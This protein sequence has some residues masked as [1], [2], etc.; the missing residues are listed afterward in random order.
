MQ[1]AIHADEMLKLM[2]GM[3]DLIIRARLCALTDVQIDEKTPGDC[4]TA[5]DQDA[6]KELTA[7]LLGK[8]PD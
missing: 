5:A 7:S 8:M 1:L 6:E 4:V 3:A 2:D